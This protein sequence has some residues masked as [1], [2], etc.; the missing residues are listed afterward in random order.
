VT[1]FGS[2]ARYYDLLYR[3]KDYAGEARFVAGRI[4]ARC[5][6]ARRILEL[7]CG[8]GA[9][10]VFL[11]R[12]GFD[13]LGVDMSAGMLA[14]A[15]KRRE[16]LPEAEA[17]RLR[18][19]R[20]DVRALRLGERFDAVVALFH[21]IGYQSS[22][23]DL[24]TFVEAAAGHLAPGGVFLFDCWHGPAVVADPP[25]PRVRT[26]EDER[27]SVVR[28]A[29]PVHLPAERLVD[30]AYRVAITDLESGRTREIRETHRMRYLF[31]E[32]VGR[33]L[34]GV[35]LDVV[36]CGEWMTGLPAGPGSWNVY[37][38]ASIPGPGTSRER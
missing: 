12:E 36:E 34:A 11:A 4:R 9:H 5:P 38:A 32:E 31:E 28:R 26:I 35:G 20:A 1:V 37:Y 25:V 30:V 19:S 16:A 10:A 13:V 2:Y 8:T 23:D 33:L 15:E 27:I 14:A 24:R 18:F 6:G 22:D 21:V 3:D 29:E 17:A 7:G